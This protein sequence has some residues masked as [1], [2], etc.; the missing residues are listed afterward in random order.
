LT[1]TEILLKCWYS[2][3]GNN[4]GHISNI[5][6]VKCINVAGRLARPAFFVTYKFLNSNITLNG[7]IS[8]KA[9]IPNPG[10]Q[11]PDGEM[12]FNNQMAVNEMA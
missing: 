1:G 5:H 2:Y 11:G 9:S 3:Q 12:S 7:I 8:M 10:V 6:A 4:D